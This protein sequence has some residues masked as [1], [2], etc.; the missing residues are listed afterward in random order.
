MRE[1][2]DMFAGMFNDDS[3]E[4]NPSDKT[5]VQ[6]CQ[7]FVFNYAIRLLPESARVKIKYGRADKKAGEPTNHL[8]Q[9][10]PNF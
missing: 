8:G 5:F 9:A 7:F 3:E 6:S 1:I 4:Q 10:F 2:E